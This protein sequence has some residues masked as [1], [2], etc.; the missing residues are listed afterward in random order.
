MGSR[1]AEIRPHVNAIAS[2]L[3]SP[4]LCEKLFKAV[5]KGK[6]R[7]GESDRKRERP[8]M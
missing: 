7:G 6:R 2:P 8:H 4:E 1:D 3:A 5:K